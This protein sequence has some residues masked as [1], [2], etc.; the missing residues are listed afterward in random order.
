MRVRCSQAFRLLSELASNFRRR[1]WRAIDFP[2]AI[3]VDSRGPRPA[4]T[5]VAKIYLHVHG[6]G[7]S[8]VLR[9]HA[10]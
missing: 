6:N 8:I 4:A 2:F 9:N 5:L 7:R 10:V 1:G 3:Y